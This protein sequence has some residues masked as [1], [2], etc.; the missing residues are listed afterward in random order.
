MSDLD[1]FNYFMSFSEQCSI[2]ACRVVM[3]NDYILPSNYKLVQVIIFD[4][5]S[6]VSVG[7]HTLQ[8][9]WG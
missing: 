1:Y 2:K 6:E 8:P 9:V 7:T 4:F 3:G 5:C